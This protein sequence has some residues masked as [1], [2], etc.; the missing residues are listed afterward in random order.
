MKFSIMPSWSLRPCCIRT[1]P[2]AFCLN[3][4]MPLPEVPAKAVN[5]LAASTGAISLFVI[6][7]SLVGIRI[8]GMKRDVAAIAIGKLVLHPLLVL[9]M[10]MVLPPMQR[11]LQLAVVLMAAVPMLGIYPIL[12]QKHGHDA[13]AAAAQLGTT[14]A[15][16]ATLTLLLWAIA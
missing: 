7:G 9:A 13:M 4:K 16:F 1:Q 14:V 6:G 3:R 10:V 12:A 15:S 8:G 11:E 2:E 5:L